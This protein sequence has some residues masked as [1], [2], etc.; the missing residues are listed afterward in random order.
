[1]SQIGSQ[2]HLPS[3]QRKQSN[4]SLY[5]RQKLAVGTA[6][7]YDG[8]S[9]NMDLNFDDESA[10]AYSQKHKTSFTAAS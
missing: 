1:M 3:Q 4:F 7:P 5:L 6:N 2:H 9:D 8:Q 10:I